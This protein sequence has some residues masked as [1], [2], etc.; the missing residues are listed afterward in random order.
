M[1]YNAR[2]PLYQSSLLLYQSSLLSSELFFE[3]LDCFL[4]FVAFGFKIVQLFFNVLLVLCSI[5]DSVA[6]IDPTWKSVIKVESINMEGSNVGSEGKTFSL[7]CKPGITEVEPE[8][9]GEVEPE[10]TE[11]LLVLDLEDIVEE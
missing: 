1:L 2:V 8:G 11:R 6:N 9:E 10:G 5:V 3:G 4:M 7:P